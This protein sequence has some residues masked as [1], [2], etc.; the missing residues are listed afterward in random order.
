MSLPSQSCWSDPL[1]YR[2][3]F[4]KAEKVGLLFSNPKSCQYFSFS[5]IWNKCYIK[6]HQGRK[7]RKRKSN[8]LIKRHI[9]AIVPFSVFS[10]ATNVNMI[11]PVSQQTHGHGKKESRQERKNKEHFRKRKEKRKK[12]INNKYSGRCCEDMR[13]KGGEKKEEN[14]DSYRSGGF[15]GAG[16]S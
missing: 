16:S 7:K 1:L 10:Q 15:P 8:P 6:S 3:L 14:T 11:P 4:W 13:A 5:F 2:Y 9:I 12:D